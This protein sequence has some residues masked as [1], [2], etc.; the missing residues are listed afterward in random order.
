MLTRTSLLEVRIK[1]KYVQISK[2]IQRD[3]GHPIGVG[4]GN[5]QWLDGTAVTVDQ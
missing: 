5:E 1:R 2:Y 3:W 4:Q